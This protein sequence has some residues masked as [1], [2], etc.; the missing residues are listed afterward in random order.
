MNCN[1]YISINQNRYYLSETFI[2]KY[3][4]LVPEEADILALCYGDFVMARIDVRERLFVSRR[5]SRRP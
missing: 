1:G 2:G 5:I 4:E 3:L